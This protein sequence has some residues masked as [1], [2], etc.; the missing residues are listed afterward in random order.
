[1][2]TANSIER[3]IAAVLLFVLG[4][5]CLVVL[6]PFLSA[7]LWALILSASTWPLYA[8]LE[9]LLGGR[10]GI[11][12]AIMV[13]GAAALFLLPLALL[14]S[15]LAPEV[16]QVAAVAS[17]WMET[18]PPAPPE[19]V[20]TVPVVG[21]RLDAYWLEIADD[22]AK[23]AADLRAY[24]GPARELVL[25]IGLRLGSGLTELAL[26]LLIAFFFYRDGMAGTQAL[27]LALARIGGDRAEHLLRL[28]AD[29]V[30]G[31]V[32][33]VLGTNLVV[34]MLAALGLRLVGLPSSLLFGFVLFFLSFI[35]LAPALIFGP[36]VIWLM[37]RGSTGSTIFLLVW[38][39]AV[40]VVLEGALRSYLISRGGALPL[41]LVFLGILGG[42]ISFGLLGVFLGPTLLAVGYALLREWN[43]AETRFGH[44]TGEESL[45]RAK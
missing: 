13:L 7:L 36:A 28:A 10:R 14:A 37:Q 15:Q 40:F 22:G 2:G 23:L 39:V 16:T 25:G 34:A 32:Y 18:G 20:K 24:I 33:G 8:R 45:Q 43:V 4:V 38:Y 11:T 9:R 6:R 17:R 41:L 31:V 3:K 26:A 30:K 19:W 21:A 44:E 12:A 27:R 35:P 42:I 1:M 29:T 5:G